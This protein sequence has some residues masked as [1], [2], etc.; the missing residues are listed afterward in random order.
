MPKHFFA[1][2]GVQ[3]VD[4]GQDPT[5]WA[6]ETSAALK[7]TSLDDKDF[8]VNRIDHLTVGLRTTCQLKCIFCFSHYK[9]GTNALEKAHLDGPRL[10]E[11]IRQHKE[12]TGN[13]ISVVKFGCIGEILIDHQFIPLVRQ[14]EAFVDEFHILTN[15]SIR[16]REMID[17]VATTEKVNYVT[18]SCDA[19]DPATYQR[20]RVN[21]DFELVLRNARK[22]AA[23][24]KKLSMHAIAFKENE[25]SLLE[26]PAILKE[27]GFGDLH[28][29]YSYSDLQALRARGVDKLTRDEFRTFFFK[30]K[31]Q[32]EKHQL[33]FSIATC[34]FD[35]DYV[36]LLPG[37]ETAERLRNYRYEPCPNLYCMTI[38]PDGRFYHC[39]DLY[40]MG[41]LPHEESPFFKKSL[42]EMYNDPVILNH[43]KLQM[44]GRFPAICHEICSK[45]DNPKTEREALLIHRL[46]Y[47]NTRVSYSLKEFSKLMVNRENGFVI[48]ALSPAAKQT[49]A[50]YPELKRKV[51]FIIDRDKKIEGVSQTVI[52]PQEFNDL[53]QQRKF[54]VLVGSE[55]ET[56]FNSVLESAD[57][58]DEI[59]R[60]NFFGRSL[61]DYQ[62]MLMNG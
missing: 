60:L 10:V 36:G 8:Y 59:Y 24:G 16:N 6:S 26:L 50:A 22:L 44:M 20:L 45:V 51:E 13:T 39:C 62:V 47:P 17:F 4:C 48:R 40:S 49:L 37:I 11:L 3:T 55:R 42:L 58:F 21:G 46:K 33:L 14:T 15:L 12:E 61:K 34:F 19:G 30:L 28:I 56:V 2:E 5:R 57:K 27:V 9:P 52:T 54:T 38:T 32:C 31:E 29:I 23:A 7:L 53:E 25:E 35:E 41:V 18:V 43:R 1:Y